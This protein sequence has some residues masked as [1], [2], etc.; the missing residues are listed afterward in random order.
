MPEQRARRDHQEEVRPYADGEQ[1]E[2]S[3]SESNIY[4]DAWDFKPRRKS[5]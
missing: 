3:F 2:R 1:L 4:G 5:Y